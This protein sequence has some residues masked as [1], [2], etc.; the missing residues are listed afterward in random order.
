MKTFVG[1]HNAI[2]MVDH[3][4]R[5]ASVSSKLSSG[6][7]SC[8][9]L[10]CTWKRLINRLKLMFNSD[11]ECCKHRC[12]RNF[13][14]D[15]KTIFLRSRRKKGRSASESDRSRNKMKGKAKPK[16]F[17]GP[18][19]DSVTWYEINY[20]GSRFHR[21]TSKTKELVAVQPRFLLFW[22]F[23]CVTCVPA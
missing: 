4:N 6:N 22:K 19:H 12:G 5:F 11:Y 7:H 15:N 1:Q 23:Y 9:M 8:S 16:A 21:G 2:I 14:H 13:M 10:H 3:K 18:F 20:T 17:M